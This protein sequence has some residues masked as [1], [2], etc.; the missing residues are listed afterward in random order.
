[1]H[2]FAKSYQVQK[3]H[4]ISHNQFLPYSVVEESKSHPYKKA[5]FQ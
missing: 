1:M 4:A 2:L 3:L 5:L